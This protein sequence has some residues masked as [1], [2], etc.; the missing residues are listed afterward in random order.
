MEASK[1]GAAARPGE[2]LEDAVARLG[3]LRDGLRA[4]LVERDEA[5]D[6]ALAA[7]V[8]GQHVLLLGP[9]GTAKSLLARLLC[10]GIADATF[11]GRLLTRFTTPEELFGP[12]DL[13]ALESGRYER[14]VEGYLPTAHVAFLDEV[15]KASS[16]ILNALLT[17][18][19]ERKFHNGVA[20]CD[21]P[22]LCLVGASNEVPDEAG[23]AALYD[24]FLARFW[25]DPVKEQRGFFRMLRGEGEERSLPRLALGDLATL[26]AA[27]L[28]MPVADDTLELVYRLR[29]NLDK[30]GV[31]V[32]DRRYRQTL[33]FLRAHALL[34]GKD[35]VDDEVFWKIE[36][37]LWSD[38]DEL[39]AVRGAVGEILAG[40]DQDAE[41]LVAR[42]REVVSFAQRH[43][44]TPEEEARALVEAHAK[45][46]RLLSEAE[47]LER[48]AGAR[49]RVTHKV[50][51]A[52][53][54]LAAMVSDLVAEAF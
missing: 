53:E 14:L 13:A 36:A 12:L 20:A 42:G 48:L 44:D 16:A 18:L 19:N 38:P 28:A 46:T 24:R 4:R 9:P 32:S 3:A 33:D 22:L 10:E 5:I 35:R 45:L 7:L 50:R 21:V 30:R 51:E 52:R 11:F 54:A 40:Y 27:A 49:G 15:F 26:R 43:W 17:L 34:A 31:F 25:I 8:A 23:L 41:A 1:Q 6:G 37:V 29:A 2:E 47:R 39:D